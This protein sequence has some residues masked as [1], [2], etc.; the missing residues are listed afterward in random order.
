M[1]RTVI[2]CMAA[3]LIAGCGEVKNS[4]EPGDTVS[5]E[6]YH[7]PKLISG[8][9]SQICNLVQTTEPAGERTTISPDR[10]EVSARIEF[11]DQDGKPLQSEVISF[12]YG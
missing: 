6:L 11:L 8:E 12:R 10:S 9:S 2:L 4:P 3:A 7:Q 5:L 1:R